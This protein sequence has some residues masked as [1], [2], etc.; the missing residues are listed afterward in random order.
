MKQEGDLQEKI[1]L[2]GIEYTKQKVE[3]N[4]RFDGM[5]SNFTIQL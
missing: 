3:I 1:Y 5:Q 4:N 2:T